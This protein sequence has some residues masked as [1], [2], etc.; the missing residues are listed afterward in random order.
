MILTN[1]TNQNEK[2]GGKAKMAKATSKSMVI[3]GKTLVG[4]RIVEVGV[5]LLGV[6][7]WSLFYEMLEF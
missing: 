4:W 3:G 2:S 6:M 1:L 5:R 7:A